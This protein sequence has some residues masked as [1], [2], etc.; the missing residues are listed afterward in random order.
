[1]SRRIILCR[2]QRFAACIT[3]EITSGAAW[4]GVWWC[5]EWSG[6]IADVIE[7]HESLLAWHGTHVEEPPSVAIGVYEAV[8]IHEP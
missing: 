1:M 5:I 7:S 6:R 8:R 3:F 2:Y 4:G